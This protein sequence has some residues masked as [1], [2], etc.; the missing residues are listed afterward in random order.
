MVTEVRD[1]SGELFIRQ[2]VNGIV[3]DVSDTKVSV[4]KCAL[5]KTTSS[6]TPRCLIE[7]LTKINHHMRII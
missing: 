2:K 1:A 3:T 5:S 4:C 7:V 6:P